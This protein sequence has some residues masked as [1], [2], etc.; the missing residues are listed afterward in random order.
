LRMDF[1]FFLFRVDLAKQIYA[2]DV[3]RFV[4]KSRGDD[5][6]GNRFQL[7]FGIGYPF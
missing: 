2:P 5:L 1:D 7:N 4:I 6:G 3:Q